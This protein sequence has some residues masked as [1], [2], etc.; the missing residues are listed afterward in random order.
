VDER[1]VCRCGKVD[2]IEKFK[3]IL[4]DRFIVS[5]FPHTKKAAIDIS[6]TAGTCW[7]IYKQFSPYL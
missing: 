1:V 3:P 7:I 4:I 2:E 6:I 5:T